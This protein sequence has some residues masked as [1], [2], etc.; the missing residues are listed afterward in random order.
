MGSGKRSHLFFLVEEVTTGRVNPSCS[1]LSRPLACH[2]YG[3]VGCVIR[4]SEGIEGSFKTV[5]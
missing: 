4:E 3:V 1:H 2:R 5:V